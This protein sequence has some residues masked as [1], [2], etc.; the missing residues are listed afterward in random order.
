[1]C[2]WLLSAAPQLGSL[3]PPHLSHRVGCKG[4][5]TGS[6]TDAVYKASRT[7]G[8]A[9]FIFCACEFMCKARIISVLVCAHIHIG[10]FKSVILWCIRPGAFFNAEQKS[11]RGSQQDGTVWHWMAVEIV[12]TLS[13]WKGR[14]CVCPVLDNFTYLFQYLL[15]GRMVNHH[16][17]FQKMSQTSCPVRTQPAEWF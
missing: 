13:G 3:N 6:R 12:D 11:D 9:R 15:V 5:M 2:R 10:A 4:R 16:R 17:Y 1:M 14:K 7:V 8:V